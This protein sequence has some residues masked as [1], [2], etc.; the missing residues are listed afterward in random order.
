VILNAWNVV[1]LGNIVICLLCVCKVFLFSFVYVPLWIY[2]PSMCRARVR[3]GPG[4]QQ[5]FWQQKNTLIWRP[6]FFYNWHT[7][8]RKISQQMVT[9]TVPFCSRALSVSK[10]NFLGRHEIPPVSKKQVLRKY[11]SVF[12]KT[13]MRPWART[14]ECVSSTHRRN[15]RCLELTHATVRAQDLNGVFMKQMTTWLFLQLA[16]AESQDLETCSVTPCLFVEGHRE[17]VNITLGK[18]WDSAGV[19]KTSSSLIYQCV[20]CFHKNAVENLGPHGRGVS[21]THQGLIDSQMRIDEPSMCRAHALVR[22]GPG[23]QRRFW[24]TDDTLIY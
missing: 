13:P 19:K 18:A 17:W 5:R 22:A 21:S 4:A 16:P 3:A 7:L 12:L 2:E 11:I 23:S 6:D 9:H 8:N 15:L 20:I 14:Y 24:K 10:P 1:S